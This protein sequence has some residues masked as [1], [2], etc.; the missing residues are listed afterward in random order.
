MCNTVLLFVYM[1]LIYSTENGFFLDSKAAHIF[2]ESG[3]EF[4]SVPSYEDLFSRL[5]NDPYLY[6]V[7]P[8]NDL[9]ICEN[10]LFLDKFLSG[11]YKILK[12][13]FLSP[14]FQ[15]V[16]KSENK[17]SRVKRILIEPFF[18]VLCQDWICKNLDKEIIIVKDLI[19]NLSQ[20]KEEISEGYLVT[21]SQIQAI[22]VRFVEKK[23]KGL[24]VSELKYFLIGRTFFDMPS[25]KSNKVIVVFRTN[26]S[27]DIDLV[28]AKLIKR[29]FSVFKLVSSISEDDQKINFYA[30]LGF[31]NTL[32]LQ[33]LEENSEYI[34][35]LGIIESGKVYAV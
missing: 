19:S 34:N 5:D 28:K 18:R 7:I 6:G 21:K 15:I 20:D 27:K 29:G 11:R 32:N 4:L 17:L 3:N 23:L 26:I 9:F 8:A 10:T 2:F 35:I 13:I 14:T 25:K 33:E 30:E 12:E 31:S 1:K 24:T 16:A 22:K